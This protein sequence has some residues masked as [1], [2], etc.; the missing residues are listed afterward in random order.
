MREKEERKMNEMMPLE[1]IES[2]I[3]MIRGKKVML[4]CDLA[5]MY[6]V[7]TRNLKRQVRRNPDRFPSDFMFILNEKEIGDLVCHF[8]TPMRSRFGGAQPFAFTEHGILMLSSVLNSKRAIEINI[9]IMRVFNK[10]REFALS[11]RSLADRIEQLENKHLKHELD[12]ST[13][14]KVLKK[15]MEPKPEKPVKRIGFSVGGE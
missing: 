8:G 1:K 2:R 7:D 6:G 10:I 13:I 3:Y 4:D 12:I 5:E 15:L 11:H 14:F 9:K